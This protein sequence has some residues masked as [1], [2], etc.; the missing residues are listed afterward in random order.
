MAF[1]RRISL[2]AATAA[3]ALGLSACAGTPTGSTGSPSTGPTADAAAGIE[4]GPFGGQQLAK[5][6]PVQGGEL[7]WG[8][9][10][11]IQS[12][13]ST[14]VMGDS[15][16]LAMKTIYGSLMT[17][18]ADGRVEPNLA[19]SLETTDNLVW[20][21]KLDPQVVFTD[22][23]PLNAESVITHITNVG[24]EGSTSTQAGD[25]RRITAMKAMDEFTVEF[26]LAKP[27]NQFG[28]MFTEGSLGLIPSPT[29][30]IAAGP[31]FA[32]N[33][34]GAGPFKVQSF[35]PGIEVVLVK[36]PD[37][38]FAD[39]GLPYL[40][41]LTLTTVQEE[42]SRID[43]TRAGSIDGG[44]VASVPS[45]EEA[46]AGGLIGL[47]QPVYSAFYLIL[48][49]GDDVLSDLRVRQALNAA[50]DRAAINQVVYEGL[51]QP[52]D[53]MLVPSHPYADAGAEWPGYDVERAKELIADYLEDTG[54]KE[55]D[56]TITIVPGG[57][58]AQVAPL[59]QQ[60]L[61][62]VGIKVNIETQDQTAL[63]GKF[64]AADYDIALITRPVQPETTTA[65]SQYFHSESS[66]N[67]SQVS[68]P[69]LD[70][71]FG[72]AA[73]ALSDDERLSYVPQML[74][75]LA[76][77]AV[78]VPIVS[79][80]AGRLVGKRVGGFPDGDPTTRT[81]EIVDFSRV[82]VTD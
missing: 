53:G 32:T 57:D 8:V 59:V 7:K 80:G 11:P 54:E 43:A 4:I 25:A 2:V 33:P 31:D 74:D 20:T 52:M 67:W 30:R 62:A 78:A 56:L 28:L 46:R 45:L 72:E 70:A 58:N 66:R 21:M 63:V 79:A 40:D 39:Q 23:T 68:I 17:A 3:I 77:H 47:E 22:G 44:T 37:Y 64:A 49:N 5:G 35:T 42:S 69:E 18:T 75:I 41:K 34:V 10:L 76:E 19:E 15:I 29:A 6:E 16:A 26:T 73:S 55:I 51:H 24:A 82:W 50:I 65:L 60:M 48:N 36:N 9:W 61:A 13:D 71:V 81:I 14:G 38:K 1:R 27:D 12:L